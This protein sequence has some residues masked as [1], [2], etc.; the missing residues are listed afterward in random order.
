MKKIF[1]ALTF[2]ALLPWSIA[3]Q[4][5]RQRTIATIIADALDQ[6]PAAKQQDYNNIMNELMSTGTAGIVLLGEML[7]PADKGKNASIEHA[8]YGVVSYVTA[9]DKAD[10]RAEV[11]KGLAKAIEKCTDNPNRAFLMSQLQRCA[12]V[13]DIP[14]FVKYLHDAYLAE[15]AIN[16]LAHTEGANEALLDLIKKEV[17]PREKLAYAVGVKRLKTAEPI[18]LEWLKNADAPTQKAIYHALSICG[19]S[20]SLSTLEKAAKAAKYEWIPETDVTACYL[21]LLKTMVVNDEGHI[22]ANAAKKLL[23]DTDKAYV[24]GAALDVIIETEGKKAVSYILA[25]LKDSNREYRVNALRLSENIADETLYANLAKT[26]K[27]K[28]NKKVKADIL[29]WFGTNHVVSQI[30]AVITNMDSDDE[31]IAIAAIT[32]AGKIGGDTALE[33]LIA[34]LN[35]NHADAATKALLSFNGKIN[36]NIMKALD[37]DKAIRIAA[38]NLASTRSMDEATDKVFNMLT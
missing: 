32:A 11:R 25:A 22:A 21:R 7:V 15:W 14:V 10:K 28:N 38:L 9:P 19:S 23:K 6:L 13:E 30:D 31:E 37:A 16:G 24:R 33:A 1:W 27:A 36:N 12:T 5:A 20:A 29:N 3:A 2:A 17:A 26:L 18:L 4:D 35:S 8:L 34:K